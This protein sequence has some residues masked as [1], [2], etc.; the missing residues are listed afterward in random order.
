M[1]DFDEEPLNKKN[2]TE[3]IAGHSFDFDEEQ[4]QPIEEAPQAELPPGEL[5]PFIGIIDMMIFTSKEPLTKAG[6]PSPNL[7]IWETWGKPNLSK[8]FIQYLP[9]DSGAGAAVNSPLFAGAL[10]FGALV[11]AFLPVILHHIAKKKEEA[12]ALEEGAQQTPEPQHNPEP[13]PAAARASVQEQRSGERIE[14][15]DKSEPKFFKLPGGGSEAQPNIPMMELI[16]RNMGAE[17]Q[18]I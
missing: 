15:P 16:A 2:I 6:Y 10:G 7:E 9:L 5:H 13:A 4:Q 17:P 3:E 8:A 14:T 12:R 11:I 18:P 1:I